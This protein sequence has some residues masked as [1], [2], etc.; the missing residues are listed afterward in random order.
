MELSLLKRANR[1]KIWKKFTIGLKM[2]RVFCKCCRAFY[3]F[4]TGRIIPLLPFR[5]ATDLPM[6]HNCINSDEEQLNKGTTGFYFCFLLPNELFCIGST[7]NDSVQSCVLYMFG[8]RL[9]KY[10]D[11]A[12]MLD[13]QR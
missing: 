11:K 10:M 8:H 6:L 3:V 4:A 2:S 12:R 9:A 7:E 1:G 5:S 13:F